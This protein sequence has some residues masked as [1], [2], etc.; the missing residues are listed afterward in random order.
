MSSEPLPRGL[1]GVGDSDRDERVC[2]RCLEGARLPPCPPG[3]APAVGWASRV[4]AGEK[5][6]GVWFQAASLCPEP[7]TSLWGQGLT[8]GGC[9][10]GLSLR[11]DPPVRCQLPQ[12]AVALIG[13]WWPWATS[14][15]Y[16]SGPDGGVPST[17]QIAP[18]PPTW[19]PQPVLPSLSPCLH[20]SVLPRHPEISWNNQNFLGSIV[21]KVAAG[22]GSPCGWALSS[23]GP[24]RLR[25]SGT[26]LLF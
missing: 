23:C 5:T 18:R 16:V 12:W 11:P 14:W 8:P 4:Q 9:E 19:Q 6:A 24:A 7:Q 3:A 13:S 10:T 2:T 17:S 22:R 25:P 1:R 21:S 26:P 15:E 20:Q